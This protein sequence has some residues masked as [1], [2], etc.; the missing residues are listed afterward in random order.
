MITLALALAAAAAPLLQDGD[1]VVFFGDSITV[2][3]GY[4]RYVE[5]FVRMRHP[6]MNITFINAG[7]GGNAGMDALARVDTDVI[8]DHPTVVFVNFGVNDAGYPPDT[9]GYAF[10]KNILAVFEKLQA[11]GVRLIVWCETT[12]VD[13]EGLGKNHPKKKREE[14]IEELVAFEQKTA[15]ANPLAQT[16]IVLVPWFKPL[17]DAMLAWKAARPTDKPLIPDT[18]H[19][20][21]GG[22]AIMAVEVLRALGFEMLPAASHARYDK[23]KATLDVD[24]GGALA[25]DGK[26]PITFDARALP[27]VPF[28]V[29]KKEAAD[30][31]VP[32][33]QTLRKLVLRV[34]GLDATKHYRVKAGDI[35]VGRFSARELAVGIDVMAWSQPRP[36]PVPGE[37]QVLLR[38]TLGQCSA[39]TGNPFLNDWECVTDML[40]EKDQLRILMRHEKT[41]AVPDF[42]P[43][44]T[45]RFF[46]LEGEWV[47]AVEGELVLRTKKL[48]DAPHPITLTPE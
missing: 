1:R 19:P 7:I 30:L 29:D 42:V 15:A 33:L 41:Y 24:V 16:K 31:G 22:Q 2:A 45:E 27:P 37:P 5:A 32:E 18:I 44:Y 40:F 39:T 48:R 35:D 28:V 12:P 10:E 26:A 46:G 38:P 25:W 20:S 36:L 47:A 6:E 23:S 8:A 13:V 14:R 17:A 34:D 11:A 4:T 3:H 43:T 21:P 9:P